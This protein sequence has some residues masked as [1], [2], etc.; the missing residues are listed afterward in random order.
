M[1]LKDKQHIYMIGIG[2]IS[3]SGLALILC[4]WNYEVSGS[5]MASSPQTEMLENHG[6]KVFIGQKRKILL[7]IFPLLFIRQRLK[8]IILSL[9]KQEI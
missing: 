6:V 2:G 8:M 7:G 9:H 5:D 3:M 1:I 4:S